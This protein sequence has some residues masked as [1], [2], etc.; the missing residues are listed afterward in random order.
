MSVKI[1][2]RLLR[3]NYTRW[4]LLGSGG[5][6]SVYKAYDKKTEKTI[7]IKELNKTKTSEK[8]ILSEVTVLSKLRHLCGKS[9]LCIIDFMEDD[10]NFYIITEYLGDYQTLLEY[11]YLNKSP[12]T[13]ET[14]KKLTD[15]LIEGL[16]DIHMT[17]VAHR[18]VKPENIMINPT[19]L[20]I[21]YID[22][23]LSCLTNN[24]YHQWRGGT[25]YYMSPELLITQGVNIDMTRAPVSLPSW[26]K[27]DYWSL[28]ITLLEV[29]TKKLIMREYCKQKY[30]TD[31]VIDFM[32]NEVGKSILNGESEF[33][34]FIKNILSDIVN[35]YGIES[36]NAM[37]ERFVTIRI[38]SLLSAQPHQRKLLAPV[39]H[40]YKY[41]EADRIISL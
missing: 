8:Y 27:S 12:M 3:D 15:N 2:K 21:K 30:T 17:G 9:A 28:G 38:L 24:C 16:N 4:V 22:F 10:V 6:G 14:I 5:Y 23:G 20:D 26:I 25:L 40:I 31:I 11:T 37:L 29:I 34:L 18:D 1:A 19:N 36:Q 32:L 7:V 41:E 39:C 33:Y 35:Q 13:Y